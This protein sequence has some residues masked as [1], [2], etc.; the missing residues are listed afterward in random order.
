MPPKRDKAIK[1]IVYQSDMENIISHCKVCRVAMIDN[2][3]PYLLA[4]CFGYRNKTIYL[5]CAK[6]G[7][8]IDVL[9]KNNRV[10][11]LFDTDHDIFARHEEV[12]CSW[13]LRYR[14]VL[15]YGNAEI[16]EDYD[17]K[18]EGLD[19]IMRSFSDREFNYSPPSVK[20][21][22]VIKIKIERM[23]GRSFEY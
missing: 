1:D 14:S 5:H 12:A 20:N 21:V 6:E 15:A 8:K 7:K 16:V 11:V 13:R 18:T 3:E 2:E 9:K 10:C 19:C 4:F 22:A 23:T 17:E